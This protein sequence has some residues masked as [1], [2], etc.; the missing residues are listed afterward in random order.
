MIPR[1]KNGRLVACQPCQRRK[2]ACDRSF[3]TCQRCQR[4]RANE[5]CRYLDRGSSNNQAS[6]IYCDNTAISFS[7]LSQSDT[8]IGTVQTTNAQA[9]AGSTQSELGCHSACLNNTKNIHMPQTLNLQFYGQ[10][11]TGLKLSTDDLQIALDILA[12]L[13]SPDAER[14]LAKPHINPFDGW[15]PLYTTAMLAELRSTFAYAF[16]Q[17]ESKR[18]EALASLIF[19]NTAQNLPKSQWCPSEDWYTTFSGPNM[20]WEMIGLLFSCW[21]LSALQNREDIDGYRPRILAMKFFDIMESCIT[22]FSRAT[23]NGSNNVFLLYLSYRTSIVSS[24]L[25]GPDSTSF[26]RLHTETVSLACS[27]GLNIMSDTSINEPLIS[28]QAERRLF[29]AIY[30]LDKTAATFTGKFPLLTLDKCSTALPLDICNTI[31]LQWM[32]GQTV[33]LVSLGV[34]DRGWNTSSKVY[35]TTSLRA[36]ALIAHNREDILT[37]ALNKGKTNMIHLFN[38]KSRQVHTFNNLPSNLRLA[39][40]DSTTKSLEPHV[41]YTRLFIRLEHLQTIFLIERV[42]QRDQPNLPLDSLIQTSL[43]IVSVTVT[44]WTRNDT[45]VGMQGDHEWLIMGYAIPAA[46]VLCEVLLQLEAH[47]W[48][49]PSLSNVMQQ[50]SLL[51]AFLEWLLT[52][53]PCTDR[54]YRAKNVIMKVLD[55][56]LDPLPDSLLTDS[57]V[58]IIGIDDLIDIDTFSW[59]R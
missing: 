21:A 34:N 36:R 13:P 1:T 12:S 32:P 48:F 57:L 53:Q 33:D 30:I 46:V 9:T 14:I 42:L 20:R 28:K 11:S 29:T 26:W 23:N 17:H 18:L 39:D 35:S 27:M 7:Q 31:L 52:K 2:Y 41:L 50:L 6:A 8:T 59:L 22:L 45:L 49:I 19:S 5:P 56:V 43:D 24:I 3:P 47:G 10:V 4:S 40:K 44:Y 38:L 37:H 55:Q 25:H 15:I 58:Q 51:G 54:C 16:R